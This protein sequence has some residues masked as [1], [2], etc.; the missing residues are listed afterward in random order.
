MSKRKEGK[1]PDL[2]GYVVYGF[3]VRKLM[4]KNPTY[5][6]FRDDRLR[7]KGVHTV[8]D[9]QNYNKHFV[10][11]YKRFSDVIALFNKKA[12]A[13]IIKGERLRLGHGLGYLT[14][15]RIERNY[16]R[17]RMDVIATMKARRGGDPTARIYYTDDD[18]CRIAWQKNGN[19]RHCYAYEFKPTYGFRKDFSGALRADPLLQFRYPFNE[20]DNRKNADVEV[21]KMKINNKKERQ[22]KAAA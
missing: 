1:L 8:Y 20:Y 5:K 17:P 9:I 11:D 13:S 19:V 10:V 16:N 18:Y 22:L 6:L 12:T 2:G 21:I 3:Y 7:T 4:G 15:K 14:A